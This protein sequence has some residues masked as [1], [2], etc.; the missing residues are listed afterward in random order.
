MFNAVSREE[1]FD[2][3]NANFPE[4]SPLTSLFYAEEGIIL[5]KWKN[6]R[7][8]NRGCPLLPIFATLVLHR[9]LKPLATKLKQQADDHLNSGDAGDDGFGS[10]AHL[11]AYMDHISSTVHQ[12]D[13]QFFCT[14]FKKLGASRG[15]FVNPLKTRILSCSGNSILPRYKWSIPI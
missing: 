6:K 9:V 2:V 15:C 11:F 8:K 10:L 3:I 5:F 14:E 13:V 1:L 4:L 12:E 7:W